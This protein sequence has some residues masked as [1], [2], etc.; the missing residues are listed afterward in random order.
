MKTAK[1]IIG[2]VSI[3]LFVVIAFQSCAVGLGNA[4]EDNNEGSGG[5]GIF[6]AVCMLIAGIVA[7]A[8]RKSRAGGFVAG[9]FYALGGLVGIVN[10]GSYSDL[11]IWSVL[12]FIFAVVM[13]LGSALKKKQNDEPQA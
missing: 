1:I 7:I 6:L 8:T 9:G 3:V 11:A 4:L 12:A 2:I 13:F 10:V 5:G